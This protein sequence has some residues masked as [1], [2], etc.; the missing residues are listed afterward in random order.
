MG[1]QRREGSHD[2][3]IQTTVW[4]ALMGTEQ[5][6]KVRLSKLHP[7]FIFVSSLIFGV[8]M[9]LPPYFSLDSLFV[10]HLLLAW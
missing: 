10:Y 5:G 4:E 7:T 9:V 2:G 8:E 6:E 3:D 1:I